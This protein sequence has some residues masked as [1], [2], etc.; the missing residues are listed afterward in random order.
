[1]S[2]TALSADAPEIADTVLGV[3]D[4]GRDEHYSPILPR[5]ASSISSTESHARIVAAWMPQA[6]ALAGIEVPQSLNL[7]AAWRRGVAQLPRDIDI[8]WDIARRLKTG[9]D[10]ATLAQEAAERLAATDAR[11]TVVDDAL[12]SMEASAIFDAAD[13]VAE[14]LDK[15]FAAAA[16]ALADAAAR[17]PD[18]W[19]SKPPTMLAFSQPGRH[20]SWAEA[21]PLGTASR[22]T[23]GHA[24][25]AF[26]AIDALGALATLALRRDSNSH[27]LNEV[28]AHD[29][30]AE[31]A[32]ADRQTLA[33]FIGGGVPSLALLTIAG[34]RLPS[35]TLRLQR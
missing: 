27:P 8:A 29:T 6:A 9:D 1:M 30:D 17:L 33:A 31:T 14:Q 28:V 5:S 26:A 3:S 35:M 25:A 4:A 7:R 34:G 16:A 2:T 20:A 15:P 13:E 32:N 24:D 18:P 19:D 12:R 10:A 11:L 21:G 23:R 22:A